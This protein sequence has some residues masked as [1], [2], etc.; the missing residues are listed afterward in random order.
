MDTLNVLAKDYVKDKINIRMN[1]EDNRQIIIKG[2]IAVR[3]SEIVLS[4]GIKLDKDYVNCLRYNEDELISILKS[5]EHLVFQSV[6]YSFI[7]KTG[8]ISVNASYS[9]CLQA[10]YIAF[11]NP[12]YDNKWFFCF[13]DDVRYVSD[14]CCELSY[15]QDVMSTWWDYWTRSSCFVEREMPVSD[16]IGNNTRPEPVELGADYVCVNTG[17]FKLNDMNFGFLVTGG[18]DKES[19]TYSGLYTYNGVVTGLYPI[20][21]IPASDTSSAKAIIQPYVENGVEDRIV[22]MFQY[23]ALLGDS[24]TSKTPWSTL[25]SIPANTDVDGYIPRHNKLLTYP[26]K[27]LRVSTSDGDSI[28]LHFELFGG[29]SGIVLRGTVLPTSQFKAYPK[30][31]A[32][33][34]DD[35]TKAVFLNTDIEVAWVGDSYKQWLANSKTSEGISFAVKQLGA[36]A[37]VIT[38]VATANPLSVAS[39]VIASGTAVAQTVN[40][41]SV[42][43]NSSSKVHGS[44]NGNGLAIGEESF[45]FT[46]QVMSIRAEYARLIDDY[47]DRYGYATNELKTPNLDGNT[48]NYVKISNDSC[49]GYGT[50]PPKFMNEINNI[51]R[52]G[53]TLWASHDGI[54][55]Y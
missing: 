2:D 39:G 34:E 4:K 42:A 5:E 51:F 41:F 14:R 30:N 55:N 17:I 7:R 11:K 10:N 50:V 40:D 44:I 22:R 48:H 54:G 8:T 43:R 45:G 19:P 47:F 18:S 6:D 33:V 25:V 29:D 38:G 46:I 1:Y 12:D 36:G 21:G 52:R 27:F 26:Y 16:S 32:G 37:G 15:T 23:P 24:Q 49:I 3:N 28:D 35:Y 31:Y 20:M 9:E 53:T 13:L